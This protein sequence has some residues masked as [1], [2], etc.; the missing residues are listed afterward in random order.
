MRYGLALSRD[1]NVAC[2]PQLGACPLSMR[3]SLRGATACLVGTAR[4]LS[5]ALS[6][7]T[8]DLF[9]ARIRADGRGV[10]TIDLER[11]VT[12]VPA[13]CSALLE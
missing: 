10:H 4:P 6:L 1:A 13:C 5:V 8:G 7:A 3:L 11:A 12:S 2:V 9:L